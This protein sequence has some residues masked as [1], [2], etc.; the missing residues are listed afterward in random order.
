[1]ECN[2]KEI[3]IAQSSKDQT[4]AQ[5]DKRKVLCIYDRKQEDQA[6]LSLI[7]FKTYILTHKFIVVKSESQI[8]NI[9]TL[10]C[11]WRNDES[12]MSQLN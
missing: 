1:M 3:T 7:N 9:S 8:L 12:L 5:C 2:N 10:C 6:G 11:S 4:T